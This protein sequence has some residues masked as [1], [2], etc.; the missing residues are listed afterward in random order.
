MLLLG[1]APAEDPRGSLQVAGVSERQL[2]A[3]QVTPVQVA[4]HP[5]VGASYFIS[6]CMFDAWLS[7]NALRTVFQWWTFII[8]TY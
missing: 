8:D 5:P 3:I 2:P 4:P 1:D 7:S 6:L